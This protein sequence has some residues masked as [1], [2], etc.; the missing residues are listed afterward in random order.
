[1]LN[2]VLRGLEILKAENFISPDTLLDGSFLLVGKDSEVDSVAFVV[3]VTAIE[4]ELTEKFGRNI[5][6]DL[7]LIP[8][9]N[10]NSP[11]FTADEFADY[12]STL[13]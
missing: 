6:I 13:A 10:G 11:H 8:Q 12:I 2:T 9:L 7:S 3:L 1:M 5:S 4:E